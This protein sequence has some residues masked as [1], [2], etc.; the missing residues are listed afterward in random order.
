MHIRYIGMYNG[1]VLLNDELMSRL[2][3]EVR[4]FCLLP[5]DSLILFYLIVILNYPFSSCM[6][7]IV[8]IGLGQ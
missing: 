8:D 3:C 6:I 2:L 4:G 1:I 5:H 7:P